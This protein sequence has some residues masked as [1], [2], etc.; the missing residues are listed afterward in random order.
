[1]NPMQGNCMIIRHASPNKAY[2][3]IDRYVLTNPALSHGAVRLYCLL[4]SMRNGAN[5]SDEYLIKVMKV[6][7]QTLHRWRLELKEKDLIYVDKVSKF[8]HIIYI[9]LSNKGARVVKQQWEN[10][11]DFSEGEDVSPE[12]A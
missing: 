12:G 8:S 11:E 9:G 10:Y 7:R 2:V 4:C 1:M 6:T 5:F 3:K